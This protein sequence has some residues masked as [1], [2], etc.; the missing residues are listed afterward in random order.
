MGILYRHFGT[1]SVSHLH[2]ISRQLGAHTH[3]HTYL[4]IYLR[5]TW[6]DPSFPKYPKGDRDRQ[7]CRGYLS[8]VGHLYIINR[9]KLALFD[10]P[11]VF[12]MKFSSVVKRIPG[13][14]MHRRG[15]AR[16][17]MAASP[18]CLIFAVSLISVD[19]YRINNPY[20]YGK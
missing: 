3:T 13:Y 14:I 16:T 11:E 9:T 17:P 18:M 5:W 20:G 6:F 19:P 12:T 15:M 1:T 4:Y 8:K 2:L 10:C 7:P